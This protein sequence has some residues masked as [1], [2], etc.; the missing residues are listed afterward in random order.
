M[1]ETD[2]PGTVQKIC[3]GGPEQ[4]FIILKTKQMKKLKFKALALGAKELLTREQL[5]QVVGGND[6]SSGS[7]GGSCTF[8]FN[9]PDGSTISCT[10]PN[11]DCGPLKNSEGV[12]IGVKCDGK[13]YAC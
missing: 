1:V 5:K 2:C 10:S 7:G 12:I 6:G 9:C 13:S 11:H 4:Q 3:F 8:S